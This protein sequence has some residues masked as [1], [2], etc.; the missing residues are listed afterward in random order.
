MSARYD[1]LG[2]GVHGFLLKA[3][4][5]PFCGN[6]ERKITRV[7]RKKKENEDS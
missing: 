2:I 7:K 5:L 1:L 4:Q 3:L 6:R